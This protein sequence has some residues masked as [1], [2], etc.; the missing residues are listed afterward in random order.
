MSNLLGLIMSFIKNEI[1]I[2]SLMKARKNLKPSIKLSEAE[3]NE[4]FDRMNRF[5]KQIDPKVYKDE[6]DLFIFTLIAYNKVKKMG[7]IDKA[8]RELLLY[9]EGVEYK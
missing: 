6:K 1:V 5:F 9:I 3:V 2:K 8:M 4:K 7:F